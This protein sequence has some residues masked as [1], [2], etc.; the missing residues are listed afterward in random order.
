M[1]SGNSVGQLADETMINSILKVMAVTM[2]WIPLSAVVDSS[3]SL[4][5][6]DLMLCPLQ[7]VRLGAVEA[8]LVLYS[9]AASGQQTCHRYDAVLRPFFEPYSSSFG[10]VMSGLDKVRHCWSRC[11]NNQPFSQAQASEQEYVI[12]KRISQVK[13]N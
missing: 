4:R 2:H 1:S 13:E 9:R 5:L 8:L 12:I 6:L 10:G 11:H 3:A 7:S